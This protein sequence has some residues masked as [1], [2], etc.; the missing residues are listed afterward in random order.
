M[1]APAGWDIETGSATTVV[2]VI[3]SGIWLPHPDLQSKIWTNAGEIPGNG[4][5]DDGNGYVDDVH[6]YDF[7]YGDGDPQ[8][9]PTSIA[10]E[11]VSH[12]THVSGCI[13]A[14]TNNGTGVAGQD[15]ACKLMA[16]KVFDDYANGQ[17]DSV[18]IQG[19]QYAIDNGANVVNMSLGG[20]GY[21]PAWDAPMA[22]ARGRGIVV[23]CAAGNDDWQFLDSQYSWYSPV[24]N[25]GPDNYVLGV[26]ATDSNDVKADFS[27][28]DGS[29][30]RTFVDVSAPG[31]TIMSTVIYDPADGFTEA[32]QDHLYM[33]VP[34]Y[35]DPNDGYRWPWSG[36]S[37]ACPMA[38][39]LAA[40]VHAQHPGFDAL[41]IINQIKATCD[42]ID[43]INPIYAGK[44]G[45]GRI[46]DAVALG[47]D[48][49]P[50]PPR[51]VMAG[52]TPNDNGGSITVS[53]SKSVDD[54][55]GAKDVVK[56][57]VY[58]ADNMTVNG[59][60]KPD[61]T[62][63]ASKATVLVG[64]PLYYL[65]TPVTDG[66]KYWYKVSC[67]DASNEVF[68]KAVGPASARDDLAPPAPSLVYAADTQNDNGGSITISWP[69][70]TPTPDFAG[71]RIYR[72]TK[73]FTKPS[74]AT[75]IVDIAG[76]PDFYSYSDTTTVDGTKY[77]YAITAYDTSGNETKT[78]TA[79]GPVASYPNFSL[80][81]SPG[82]SMI[83]IG[84]YPPQTD[85]ATLLGIAPANL[86]LLRWD[87]TTSAYHSYQSN[88]SD[89]FLTAAPGRGYW[90]AVTSATTINLSA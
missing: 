45:A 43:S 85:M 71:F 12:G 59:I 47:Y 81:L 70:Y 78:V 26:A 82:I 76:D 22:E 62:T 8:P 24:C 79:V 7:A 38:A 4:I 48:A 72:A 63:W 15:W 35:G 44:L 73:S 37:M 29:T 9:H 23:V 60:D 88:P 20:P 33:V 75:K 64:N 54:G 6:G 30:G 21:D 5:D 86:K 83:A 65:D 49:P 52:D 77:Y 17:A 41:T 87:P 90:I 19:F 40:L 16:V 28:Y 18:I 2:A 80:T 27:N 1:S 46:N 89:P 11:D 31:V 57:T 68:S 56:Y 25:D 39:G 3:D 36:T 84:A 61:D 42:N 13:G 69:G 32:Y 55:K 53:W 50:G 34:I 14:A 74:D 51:S 66:V 10:Q 67:S 58:R